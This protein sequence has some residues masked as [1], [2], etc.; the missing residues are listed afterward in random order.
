MGVFVAGV[1]LKVLRT[2]ARPVYVE[3]IE[4]ANLV[5]QNF[6]GFNS[7]K[8]RVE[9]NKTIL[10]VTCNNGVTALGIKYDSK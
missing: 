8:A 4:R 2:E 6:K 9:D 3:D 10:D 1:G 5:C 7:I